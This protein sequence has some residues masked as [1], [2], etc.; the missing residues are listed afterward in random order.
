MIF[1]VR[2]LLVTSIKMLLATI[3]GSIW[4]VQE[5]EWN[6]LSSFTIRVGHGLIG[7]LWRKEFKIIIFVSIWPENAYGMNNVYRALGLLQFFINFHTQYCT[8]EEINC[9]QYQFNLVDICNVHLS[10]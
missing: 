5:N 1:I 2:I 9:I 8:F 3:R 4:K 6:V 7:N 10:A